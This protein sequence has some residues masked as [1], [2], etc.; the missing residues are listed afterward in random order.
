MQQPINGP[1]W[2]DISFI[3]ARETAGI[4]CILLNTHT[5]TGKF[6]F[7]YVAVDHNF[8]GA[9]FRLPYPGVFLPVA[10]ALR[11]LLDAAQLELEQPPRPQSAPSGRRRRRLVRRLRRGVRRTRLLPLLLL[12]LLRLHH[13]TDIHFNYASRVKR[14]K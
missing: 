3:T 11:L 2:A 7:S 12:R 9:R 4:S 1:D 10:E 6:K 8:P 5:H 13:M 14:R